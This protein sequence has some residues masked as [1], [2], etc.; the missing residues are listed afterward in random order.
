MSRIYSTSYR[1]ELVPA[2][3][4]TGAPIPLAAWIGA[5]S[6]NHV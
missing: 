5:T 6:P 1:T 3:K 4:D 2:I